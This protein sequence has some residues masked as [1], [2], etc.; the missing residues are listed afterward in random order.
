MQ[1]DCAARQIVHQQRLVESKPQQGFRH[2]PPNERAA[3]RMQINRTC[4]PG[5][6]RTSTTPPTMK[7]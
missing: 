4:V 3:Q 5:M 6:Q 1:V 7:R 2:D